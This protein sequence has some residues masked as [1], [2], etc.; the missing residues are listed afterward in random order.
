MSCLYWLGE[1]WYGGKGRRGGVNALRARKK[2]EQGLPE[3]KAMATV[4]FIWF[5]HKVKFW[6]FLLI[7]LTFSRF[8]NDFVAQNGSKA[9][10]LGFSEF[11]S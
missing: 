2:S 5:S 8:V 11:I 1:G 7:S 10:I 9:K 6:T 3:E 4:F